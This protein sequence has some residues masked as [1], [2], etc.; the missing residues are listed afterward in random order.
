MIKEI[1]AAELLALGLPE[2]IIDRAV[3]ETLLTAR[4]VRRVQIINGLEPGSLQRAL[5]G[6]RVGTVIVA[7][8]RNP[9]PEDRDS[10]LDRLELSPS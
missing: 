9:Q 10:K 3:V 1:E 4:H 6:E 7:S 8:G 2:L 5:E